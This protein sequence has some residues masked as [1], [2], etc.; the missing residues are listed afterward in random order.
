MRAEGKQAVSYERFKLAQVF[1]GKIHQV[2]IHVFS[3]LLDLIS[4]NAFEKL[5]LDSTFQ[6]TFWGF[7]YVTKAALFFNAGLCLRS[8]ITEAVSLKWIWKTFDFHNK[9]IYKS[10]LRVNPLGW[11]IET[12]EWLIQMRG[13]GYHPCDSE[14]MWC[15]PHLSFHHPSSCLFIPFRILKYIVFSRSYSRILQSF[16]VSSLLMTCILKKTVINELL[17]TS[18]TLCPLFFSRF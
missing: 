5:L 9:Y 1:G 7:V 11:Q 15:E 2:K 8:L 18:A 16:L 13:S 17:T 6:K 14:L 10:S 3:A 12:Q 4:R